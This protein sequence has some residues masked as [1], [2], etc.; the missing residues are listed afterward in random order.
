MEQIETFRVAWV[1]TDASGRIHY[2]A[3]LKWAE[4]TEAALFRRVGILGDYG[5]YPRRHVEAEYRRMLQFDD[6]VQVRLVVAGVGR[7]SVRFEWGILH[8]GET[9]VTGTH[10]VVFVSEEGRAEPLRDDVRAAL[11]RL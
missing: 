7:T 8:R 6:E 11:T 9:A 2:T 5:R 4:A 1:D 3:A 10:T